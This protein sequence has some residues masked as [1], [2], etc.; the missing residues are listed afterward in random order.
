MS[1][2][3]SPADLEWL[4]KMLSML[5]SE[6]A[7][8]RASFG[9]KGNEFIKQRG[10][11]WLE[12]FHALSSPAP[13]HSD[14]DPHTLDHDFERVQFCLAHADL[15]GD[16][17]WQTFLP[18]IKQQLER[19]R[20]LSPKQTRIL[21]NICLKVSRGGAL[22]SGL[23]L[24]GST[25][26]PELRPY[27]I[28]VIARFDAEVAAGRRRVLLVAPTGSGKTVIAG[29]P[30]YDIV[31]ALHADQRPENRAH[32]SRGTYHAPGLTTCPE[33]T[34]VRWQGK[35]CTACE[36]QPR[37]KPEAFD[38]VDGDLAEV[39]RQRRV[40]GK[41]YAA[42]EKEALYRQLLWLA[43]NQGRKLGWAAHSYKDKFGAW[44]PKSLRYATPLVPD[45]EVR[46]W[47]RS[48]DIAY[49]RQQ[50]RPRPS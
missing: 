42:A 2:P 31:W 39:D 45:E 15:C 1:A 11:T 34:A 14:H 40:K 41:V 19:R 44:P 12:F 9:A 30:D 22:M 20:P 38:V 25:A 48:R 43:R 33:C 21:D 7:G 35:P 27:Q 50:N 10:L 17:E 5:G 13:A 47:V 23:I 46:A 6:H 18:S 49:A 37:P 26:R 16:R 4:A 8:E 36:W 24:S 3:F 32:A 28:D 29:F